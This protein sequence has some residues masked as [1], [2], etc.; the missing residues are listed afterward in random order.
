MSTHG[1]IR[2]LYLQRDSPLNASV[3]AASKNLGPYWASTFYLADTLLAVK[4]CSVILVLYFHIE[5]STTMSLEDR[6]NLKCDL[7]KNPD[8]KSL[9]LFPE[10]CLLLSRTFTPWPLS[11]FLWTPLLVHQLNNSTLGPFSSL[12][13]AKILKCDVASLWSLGMLQKFRMFFKQGVQI[14]NSV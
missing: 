13:Y 11:F 2:F 8:L 3:R 1:S 6:H 9:P 4:H 12:L 5:T 7:T 10:T 14:T